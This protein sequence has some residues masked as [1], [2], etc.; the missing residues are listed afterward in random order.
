MNQEQ[1]KLFF[2]NIEPQP[3]VM[4]AWWP[5]GHDATVSIR[6]FLT[7]STPYISKT[8]FIHK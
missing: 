7:N 3:K 1:Q 6:L 2:T 4:I 5:W 8:G